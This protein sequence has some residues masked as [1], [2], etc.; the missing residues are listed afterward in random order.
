MHNIEVVNKPK[1]ALSG[2]K[3]K[4]YFSMPRIRDRSRHS[5]NSSR[6]GIPTYFKDAADL[7]TSRLLKQ[8]HKSFNRIKEHAEGKFQDLMEVDMKIKQIKENGKYDRT[9]IQPF[10]KNERVIDGP[11]QIKGKVDL[12]N[13][14]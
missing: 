3:G 12:S 7:L 10:N 13:K 6:S 5:V 11:L 9:V 8:I 1:S 14:R 4:R 2:F